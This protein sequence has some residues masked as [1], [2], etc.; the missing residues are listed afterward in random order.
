MNALR[1]F[2]DTFLTSFFHTFPVFP[3][4]WN[5]EMCLFP[6][7]GHAMPFGQ[8]MRSKWASHFSSVLNR[9]KIS[10]M[11]G[12]DFATAESSSVFKPYPI[13][14]QIYTLELCLLRG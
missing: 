12:W 9:W 13:Y 10:I 2:D 3:L 4:A 11:E 6:H 5:L 1:V 7:L 8:R 14:R